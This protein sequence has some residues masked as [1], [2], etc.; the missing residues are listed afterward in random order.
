MKLVS[1]I[2]GIAKV[3]L[4]LEAKLSGRAPRDTMARLVFLDLP[5][6]QPMKEQNGAVRANNMIEY[7]LH[8]G[9]IC[10]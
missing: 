6:A 2:H 5:S 4:S 9:E 8:G 10:D 1:H 3:V 7:C